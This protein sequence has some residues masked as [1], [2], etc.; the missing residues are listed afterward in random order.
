MSEYSNVGLSEFDDAHVEIAAE[1]F[2]MLADP[3]GFA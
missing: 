1:I 2:S 3:T